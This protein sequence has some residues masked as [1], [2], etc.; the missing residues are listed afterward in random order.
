MGD[1]AR[2]NFITEQAARSFVTAASLGMIVGVDTEIKFGHIPD[3]DTGQVQ[4]VWHLGATIQEYVFPD[5]PGGEALTIVSDNPADVGLSMVVD[6]LDVAGLA[7]TADVVLDGVNLV[8]LVDVVATAVH[9]IKNISNTKFEGEVTVQGALAPNTIFAVA[10]LD[11]QQ[12]SQAIYTVPSNKV[13]LIVGISNSLNR[14]V[15][16][17]VKSIFE[18]AIRHPNEVFRTRIRYGL[19]VQGT[20]NISSI[21]AVPTPVPPWSDIKMRAEPTSNDVDV[22]SEISM[23]LFD[24]RLVPDEELTRMRSI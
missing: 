3:A 8:T 18:L 4:D 1:Q 7:Q 14:G 22:S 10:R 12:T 9:R 15:G 16:S 6:Y 11:D 5:R 19:Q 13:G 23:L 2:Q 17:D 20:S 21:L 24:T